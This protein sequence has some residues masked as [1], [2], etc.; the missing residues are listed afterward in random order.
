MENE[1]MLAKV[2]DD[3][4]AV[5]IRLPLLPFEAAKL[6]Q[7]G[8]AKLIG[9]PVGA[10]WNDVKGAPFRIKVTLIAPPDWD[11]EFGDITWNEWDRREYSRRFHVWLDRY[12]G[13]TT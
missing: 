3:Q 4:Q 9:V 12:T 7:K 5:E 8:K 13:C 11:G 1:I 6:S 10:N 2:T